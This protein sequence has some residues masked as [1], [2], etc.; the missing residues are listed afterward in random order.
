MRARKSMSMSKKFERQNRERE[1]VKSLRGFD[2]KFYNLNNLE[3]L[4]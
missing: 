3:A 4:F 2:L 1:R